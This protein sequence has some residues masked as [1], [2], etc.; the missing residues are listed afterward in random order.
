MKYNYQTLAPFPSS[1][2]Y[3]YASRGREP[4]GPRLYDEYERRNNE[5]RARG[6]YTP[7]AP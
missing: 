6:N 1:L 4:E 7:V 5:N 3:D 2:N